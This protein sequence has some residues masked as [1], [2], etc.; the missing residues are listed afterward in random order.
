MKIMGQNYKAITPELRV[1]DSAGQK[2]RQAAEKT[3]SQ[4]RLTIRGASDELSSSRFVDVL[5]QKIS[6]EVN[7]G[8]SPEKLNTLKRQIAFQEYDINAADIIRKM[9][10]DDGTEV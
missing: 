3:E 9:I 2:V 7:A 1:G 8:A 5:K 6:S 10:Q 4:D